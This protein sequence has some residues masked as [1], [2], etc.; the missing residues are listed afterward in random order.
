MNEPMMP[1]GRWISLEGIDGSGKSTLLAGLATHLRARGIEPIVIREPGGTE[2][3]EGIRKL[4]LDPGRGRPDP[5]TEMLLYT[6]SRIEQVK[7]V[8]RPA[9]ATGRW[10]LADRYA[11]ATLAYQ[12]YGRGLAPDRIREL[13]DWATAAAWPDLTVLVDCSPE[14]ACARQEA[15]NR[16]TRDRLE[17]EPPAFFQRVRTGYL[18]LAAR[19]PD[20]IVVL[21]A[22][23][24]EADVLTACCAI[25]ARRFRELRSF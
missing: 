15:R 21:D 8:V 6:A 5:W 19:E 17:S 13:H 16:P 14:T 10:V 23:P 20:R 7:T 1:Q 24:P 11:D 9:L 2:W 3:G 12:G 4:L 22:E 25:L 18:E